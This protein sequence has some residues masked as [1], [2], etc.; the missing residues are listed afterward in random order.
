M[1]FRSFGLS[2]TAKLKNH[3][4]FESVYGSPRGWAVVVN[5][6][7]YGGHGYMG[8]SEQTIIFAL[9]PVKLNK[10]FLNFSS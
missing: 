6:G 4:E 7:H 9:L 8:K 5:A 2:A 10:S 3:A 1:G